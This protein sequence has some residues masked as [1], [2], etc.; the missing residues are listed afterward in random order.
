MVFCSLSSRIQC[1]VLQ[2]PLLFPVALLLI[3][4]LL[5]IL[6]FLPL[7]PPNFPTGITK[8]HLLLLD[9]ISSVHMWVCVFSACSKIRRHS[10]A[11]NCPCHPCVTSR[12]C[13]LSKD[14]VSAQ[15]RGLWGP[16]CSVLISQSGRQQPTGTLF[17]M[18]GGRADALSLCR[19]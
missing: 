3:F 6:P 15:C 16:P 17:W 14:C 11:V 1:T 13:N 19:C 9:L 12:I 5:C 8:F 18:W 7:R 2:C 10:H 4:L